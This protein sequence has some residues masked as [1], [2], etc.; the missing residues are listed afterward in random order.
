[1]GLFCALKIIPRNYLSIL[2]LE[3]EIPF[4]HLPI[5]PIPQHPNIPS[6]QLWSEAEL[7]SI[8]QPPKNCNSALFR[9]LF[10]YIILLQQRYCRKGYIRAHII[11][12][13]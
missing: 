7:N 4:F 10:F 8:K 2:S 1:M 5:T 3:N 6:F 13:I 12:L 9:G 11:C